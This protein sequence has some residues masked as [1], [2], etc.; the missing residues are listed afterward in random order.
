MRFL[1]FQVTKERLVV[2]IT[3]LL[4][5]SL[6]FY[7]AIIFHQI[8]FPGDLLI[9]ENPYKTQ[10]FLGYAPGGYPNI[11]QGMD[12]ITELLPWKKFAIEQLQHGQLPFWNPH[13]FSGNIIMQNFQSAIFYPANIFFFITSFPTAWTIFI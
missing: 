11:A 13:N 12:V 10:S 6:F 1:P 9:S 4:V 3:S 7:K 2:L 5:V 8:P